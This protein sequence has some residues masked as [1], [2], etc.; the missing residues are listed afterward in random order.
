M[1]YPM[2]SFPES[3]VSYSWT[4]QHLAELMDQVLKDN[5]IAL[6]TRRSQESVAL[7]PAQELS[8]ILETLALLRSPVNAQRLFA[9]IAR[10][11]SAEGTPQTLEELKTEIQ[12]T[13]D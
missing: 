7:I 6:I 13:L 8:N 2:L 11:E 4:R 9:A 1:V 12:K 5:T 3:E 10:A